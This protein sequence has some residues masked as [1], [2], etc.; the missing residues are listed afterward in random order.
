MQCKQRER[1]NKHVR[2]SDVVLVNQYFVETTIILSRAIGQ[3]TD[4]SMLLGFLHSRSLIW[5]DYLCLKKNENDKTES[6][7]ASCTK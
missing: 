1:I 2:V 6:R 3:H 7:G 4:D 5:E